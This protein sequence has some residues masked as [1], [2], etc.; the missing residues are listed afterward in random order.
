M[1]IDDGIAVVLHP[2]K[3]AS[4]HPGLLNEFELSF[5]I[6]VEAH[7]QQAWLPAAVTSVSVL[8]A[9]AQ[10]SVAVR[11]VDLDLRA[12]VKTIAWIGAADVRTEWT[13]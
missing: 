5:D 1:R 11:N 12:R 9:D 4:Q 6:R 10:Y 3:V 7:E 8:A 2:L 13:A